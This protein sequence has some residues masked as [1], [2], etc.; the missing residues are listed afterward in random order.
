MTEPSSS[1][2]NSTRPTA[3]IPAD[4]GY[5]LQDCQSQRCTELLLA[6]TEPNFKYI[7]QSQGFQQPVMLH[8]K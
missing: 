7:W 8:F 3:G 6:G 2:V 1:W 5:F 4:P